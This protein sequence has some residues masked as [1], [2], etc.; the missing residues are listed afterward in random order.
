MPESW[1]IVLP[2]NCLFPL[3]LH[4]VGGLLG[5]MLDEMWLCTAL[6]CLPCTDARQLATFP[7]VGVPHNGLARTG[8]RSQKSARQSKA[9]AAA[10][11]RRKP[12]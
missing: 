2:T 7:A 4:R 3:L 9:A 12:A 6:T 5:L 10:A 8:A 1:Q 11:A